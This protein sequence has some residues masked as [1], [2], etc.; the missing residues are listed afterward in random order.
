MYIDI[1]IYTTCDQSVPVVH[2]HCR[3]LY[4]FIVSVGGSPYPGVEINEKFIGLLQDGYRME[5][6]RFA[7]D[8]MLVHVHVDK[9]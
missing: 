5:K 1:L 3:I 7:S 2:W 6:P 4:A 9:E 8:E